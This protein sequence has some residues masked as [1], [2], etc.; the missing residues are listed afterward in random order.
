MSADSTRVDR[1]VA[2]LAYEY[3][4]EQLD[5]ANARVG[6]RRPELREF[7]DITPYA[8][9]TDEQVARALGVARKQVDYVAAWIADERAGLLGPD[10]G[11]CEAGTK[12][13][14]WMRCHRRALPD[15]R[16]CGPHH[17]TPPSPTLPPARL[18]DWELKARPDGALLQA[19]YDLTDQQR[20]LTRLIGSVLDRLDRAEQREQDD[21]PELLT[22]Q[23]AAALLGVTHRTIHDMC[24]NHRLPWLRIGRQYRFRPR[25][26][27]AWLAARVIRTLR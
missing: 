21:G 14:G 19:I 7:V 1:L 6:R 20:D 22:T 2:A 27:D 24:R 23:Q 4:R 18:D 10:E 11:R 12:R 17:P 15:E 26:L 16:W 25:D 9:L 3:Q 5:P 13:W 8:H